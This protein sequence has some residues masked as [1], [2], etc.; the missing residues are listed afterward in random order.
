MVSDR[1]DAR[2]DSTVIRAASMAF[3]TALLD[4]LMPHLALAARGCGYA[5][6]V[7]GSRCRDIDMIAVP[8]TTEA[9]TA[10]FLLGR[11][12]GTLAGSVGRAIQVGQWSDKPHGR[13]A[14]TIILP[15]M[16][17]EIDLSVT[18]RVETPIASEDHHE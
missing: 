9:D 12:I 18:P 14:I 4:D 17:P 13:R 2:T 1:F 16:C 5:L 6:A 3:V 10:E 11:L 7:H 15:G 8:W